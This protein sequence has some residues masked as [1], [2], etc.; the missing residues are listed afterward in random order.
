MTKSDHKV[1]SSNHQSN[2]NNKMK[3]DYNNN[4]KLN[5]QQQ[6]NYRINHHDRLLLSSAFQSSSPSPTSSKLIKS[7][8]ISKSTES[9]FN[10]LDV[11][12]TNNL[13]HAI[14]SAKQHDFLLNK[15]EP[16]KYGELVVL[17]YVSSS[18]L[19]PTVFQTLTLLL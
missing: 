15:N 5:N 11:N 12:G 16:V 1:K 6:Q 7:D 13:N 17:G 19:S 3:L 9:I 8:F 14:S 10:N 4:N 18:N 2:V